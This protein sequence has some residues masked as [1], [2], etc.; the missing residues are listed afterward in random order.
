MSN[1]QDSR[2]LQRFDNY[3]RALQR[4]QQAVELAATRALSDLEQQG[5]IQGFESTHELAWNTLKDFLSYRGIS[6]IIGSRDATRAAFKAGLI[7]DGEVWM[8]MMKSRNLTSHTYREEV[9]KEIGDKVLSSY[10]TAFVALQTTLLDWLQNNE[11]V[12]D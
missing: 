1:S 7:Q 12:A 3:Q 2:W 5:V 4:L 10:F 11:E 8:D 6:N 9:A